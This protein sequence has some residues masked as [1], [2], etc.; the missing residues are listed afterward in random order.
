MA[1]PI[2]GARSPIRPPCPSRKAAA[3]LR[4]PTDVDAYP[5]GASPFGVMDLVGNVWQWTD[6]YVDEHTRA[7]VVRGGSYYRPSGSNVVLSAE[8]AVGPARQVP[9][10]RPVER[11]IGDARFSLRR[12][13]GDGLVKVK[14]GD[15][16]ENWHRVSTSSRLVFRLSCLSQWQFFPPLMARA[17][18]GMITST[19]S[20]LFRIERNDHS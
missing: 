14:I 8:Y 16:A 5:K 9:A 1:G 10:H 15:P 2:P 18:C 20:Y 3:T 11:P 19:N 7:A 4:P 17:A 12:G 13:R 6:E